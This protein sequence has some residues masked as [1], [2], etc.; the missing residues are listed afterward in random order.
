MRKTVAIIGL[1]LVLIVPL[2][3]G[4][5]TNTTKC[6]DHV[7]RKLASEQRRY[8]AVLFGQPKAEK[9]PLGHVRFDGDGDPWVKIEEDKWITPNEPGLE[10]TDSGMD[11]LAEFRSGSGIFMTKRVLTSELVPYLMQSIRAYQCR[12]DTIC[13]LTEESTSIGEDEGPQEVEVHPIGCMREELRSYKSCHLA[14]SPQ[15]PTAK[16]VASTYCQAVAR[17]ALHREAEMLRLA[18]EYDAAYRTML[19]F[20]GDFDQFL[21][22]FR[23]PLTNTLRDATYLIG[24]LERIPCFIGS[25]DDWPIPDPGHASSSASSGPST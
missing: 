8:R 10:Y 12:M 18:V 23:W 5:Q 2:S 21:K 11:S 3:V 22:E 19:Q 9:S 14:D 1:L 6:I 13:A 7:N 15:D 16:P 20:A 24:W 4:A 25:C 17:E